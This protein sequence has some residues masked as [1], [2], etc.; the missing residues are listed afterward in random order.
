MF[1]FFTRR[2]KHVVIIVVLTIVALAIA[3]QVRV[4]DPHTFLQKRLLDLGSLPSW[5]D[6]AMY[7]MLLYVL[8]LGIYLVTDRERIDKLL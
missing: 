3:S 1:D 6:W 7:P 4:I 8:P 5:E 2:E